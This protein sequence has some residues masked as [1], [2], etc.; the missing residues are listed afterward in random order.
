MESLV[1]RLEDSV[2]VGKEVS[3]G[4]VV[5]VRVCNYEVV[6]MR[7]GIICKGSVKRIPSDRKVWSNQ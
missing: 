2:M 7:L 3:S 6:G 5:E 1:E 4:V